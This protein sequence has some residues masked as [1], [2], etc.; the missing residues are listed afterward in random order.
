MRRWLLALA[1]GLAATGPAAAQLPDDLEAG[2]YV[3]V[4][5][6]IGAG[7]RVVAHEVEIVPVPRLEDR[8][9]GPL[10]SRAPLVIAGVSVLLEPGARLVAASGETLD[11]EALQRGEPVEARG[12]YT[13]GSLRAASL[14]A[15][16]GDSNGVELDGTIAAVDPAADTVSV[17]GVAVHVTPETWVELD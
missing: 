12:R 11:L 17:L 3:E 4:E 5:G 10:E 8:V 16:A 2:A 6:E 15:R 7:G 14:A 13:D 9:R 1:A